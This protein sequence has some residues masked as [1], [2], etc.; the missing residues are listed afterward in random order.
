METAHIA[1]TTIMEMSSSDDVDELYCFNLCT[2][3]RFSNLS[4]YEE[5]IT[6]DMQHT[7]VGK[8]IRSRVCRG[9][10]WYTCIGI[11]VILSRY[12]VLLQ[13]EDTL[14]GSQDSY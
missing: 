13:K 11:W 12:G 4:E 5:P 7:G 2:C 8:H 10:R 14:S 3:I 9:S 6:G 1:Y